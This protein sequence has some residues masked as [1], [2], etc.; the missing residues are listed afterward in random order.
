MNKVN[1]IIDLIKSKIDNYKNNK[2]VSINDINKLSE[3]VY[4]HISEKNSEIPYFVITDIIGRMFNINITFDKTD[5]DINLRQWDKILKIDEININKSQIFIKIPKKYQQIE[6]QFTYLYELPQPEQRTKEW[7]DYRYNRIT[8]SDTATAIDCNP[9]ESVESFVCKKCDPNFPFLDNDFVFH[10]KKYEQIATSLYEHLY[11]TKVTEFGCVPS[12]KHKILG[13]S[14]D[15]IS[16]KSTLDYKFNKKL[17]YML[18]IKCPYVRPITN[19]GAIAG[20]ICPYYYYCQVQQ[21]LECC[22]LEFCDFIQCALVEYPDRETY[23]R[24]VNHEFKITEDVDGR[25]MIVDNKMSKGY[26]LQFLPKVYKPTFDGDKHIYKGFFIYPPRL[27]M[28]QYQYD[29]WALNTISTW[30]KDYPDIAESHFF[31]RILYW[32]INNAH[33]VTIPRDKEWFAKVLPVLTD[34]WSKVC[35]YREHIEEL[36]LVQELATKRKAFYRYKTEFKVNNYE[37]NTAFLDTKTNKPVAYNKPKGAYKS[38]YKSNN[39]N[40]TSKSTFVKKTPTNNDCDF[41]DD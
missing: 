41:V 6:D 33:T 7:F 22:D 39:Y 26:V 14:P 27:N 34:T 25:D 40:S 37:P 8:A 21:Q 36:P 19:K 16:S 12:D 4:S 30:Q 24:D 10:G 29:T 31:D 38:T 11:N 1:E 9:Y 17:G 15:G 13:A 28:D 35:Y 18:E 32:K 2:T 5:I 20:D 3:E 23:L